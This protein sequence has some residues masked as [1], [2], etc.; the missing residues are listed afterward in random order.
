MT[1]FVNNEKNL[2]LPEE[3]PTGSKAMQDVV[4][5]VIE[6]SVLGFLA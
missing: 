5:S 3:F 4:R 2:T 1:L 6:L